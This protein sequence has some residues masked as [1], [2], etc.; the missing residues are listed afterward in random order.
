MTLR[1]RAAP[2]CSTVHLF[3][4]HFMTTSITSEPAS[5]RKASSS[6]FYATAWGWHFYSGL[7]VLPFLVMLSALK[8]AL[9]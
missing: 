4:F 7:Y 6:R 8:T 1:A 2:R 9:S 3:G 5:E